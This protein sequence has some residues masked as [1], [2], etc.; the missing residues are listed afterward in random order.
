LVCQ[1][2]AATMS[3]TNASPQPIDRPDEHIEQSQDP[4]DPNKQGDGS[5]KRSRWGTKAETAPA[6]TP[7]PPAKRSRWGSEQDKVPLP[8]VPV[9]PPGLAGLAPVL[10]PLDPE[11]MVLQAKIQLINQKLILPNLDIDPDPAKRSPSPEPVYDKNGVRTNTRI[12][13]HRDKLAKERDELMDQILKVNPNYKPPL[14]FKVNK[15]REKKIM[16]PVDKYPDYNFFGIIIGPR[17][18]TQKR[19]EK[20]TG[21]KIAIRGKGAAKPGK[22]NQPGD[23]EPLHVFISADTDD[24]LQKAADIIERLLVPMEEGKNDHKAKQL[25]ELAAIN[26][27]LRDDVIC[28]VCGERG[29]RIYECPQRSS[30]WKP[31]NVVCDICGAASHPTADCPQRDST[32]VDPGALQK[33]YMNFMAELTGG[34]GNATVLSGSTSTGP[35]AIT[36]GDIPQIGPPVLDPNHTPVSIFDAA[37]A[38]PP[39]PPPPPSIP[40][41]LGGPPVN[42]GG[43]PGFPPGPPPPPPMNVGGPPGFPPGPP[44]MNVGGPPGPPGGPPLPYAPPGFTTYAPMY[45]PQFAPGYPQYP[46]AP[47]YY[48]PYAPGGY[49][50]YNMPPPGGS[51][52]PPPGANYQPPP[53]P[54][55]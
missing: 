26:G 39:P 52:G 3:D 41:G 20:E 33:E 45:P 28:R 7:A 21:A 43:P 22:K 5:R 19:M 47:A 51:Y 34:G 11:V 35:L 9:L 12:Q 29:H 4:N 38:P 1:R 6:S 2:F 54:P 27:T 17:G 40:P 24:A 15:K 10:Q 32:T 16:I 46:P 42:V 49:S 50:S 48:P 37:P 53:P 8:L 44:P 23:D 18:N 13:R 30:N 36:A 55:P 25:R 31:A 14:G